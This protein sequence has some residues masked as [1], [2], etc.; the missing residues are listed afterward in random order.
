M[1]SHDLVDLLLV[2]AVSR[3]PKNAA[4]VAAAARACREKVR[5]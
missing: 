4:I 2:K 3:R 5:N 1:C